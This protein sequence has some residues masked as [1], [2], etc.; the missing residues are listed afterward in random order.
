MQFAM[1]IF[2]FADKYGSDADGL[3]YDDV[4][5]DGRVL[6]DTHRTWVQTEALK[7][8][9]AMSEFTGA[10]HTVRI[11][12]LTDILLDRYLK[13]GRAWAVD[14]PA[15]RRIENQCCTCQYLLPYV[16]GIC[17]I[18]TLRPFHLPKPFPPRCKSVASTLCGTVELEL[19]A[20]LRLSRLHLINGA[21]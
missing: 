12:Q 17:R 14:R 2:T 9:I 16:P 19:R 10:N 7:G 18:A 5:E 6:N 4:L 13:H 21:P 20:T 15:Y 11:A 1:P 3:V 8:Y